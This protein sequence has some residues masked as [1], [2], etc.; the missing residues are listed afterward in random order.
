MRDGQIV[1]PDAGAAPV[2]L[3]ANQNTLDHPPGDGVSLMVTPPPITEPR[4][5]RLP[6]GRVR[7]IYE[8]R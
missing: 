3:A 6:V 1:Q 4:S 7:M 5:Q 8:V 2:A